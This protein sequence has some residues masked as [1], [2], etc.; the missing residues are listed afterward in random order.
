PTGKSRAGATSDQI[1]LALDDARDDAVLDGLLRVNP[2]VTL[3]VGQH[4]GV[5]LAGLRRDHARDA[6]A[7]AQDLL[8]LDRDV[9]GLT[10]SASG[11]LVDHE[12]RVGQADP[13]LLWRREE[14]MAARAR[15]PA[16]AHRS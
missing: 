12:T 15:D 3:H 7:R 9:G 16:R 10:A 5:R 4:G 11:R 8:G 13:A 2:E 14:H 1:F 6:F